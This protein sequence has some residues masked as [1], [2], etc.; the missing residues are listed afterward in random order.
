M[1]KHTAAEKGKLGQIWDTKRKTGQMGIPEKLWFFSEMLL[2]IGTVPENS[3]LMVT[4]TTLCW[5]F[6]MQ[7]TE[8]KY[9]NYTNNIVDKLHRGQ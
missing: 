2:K 7:S 5:I 6:T 4:L 1:R 8:A 9:T 3:G